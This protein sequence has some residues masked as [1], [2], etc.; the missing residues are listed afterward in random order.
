MW[1]FSQK[2]PFREFILEIEE[3]CARHIRL[4]WSEQ[5][6][7]SN[8]DITVQTAVK[9]RW[10]KLG[11][12]DLYIYWQI[13][14]C[15]SKTILFLQQVVAI[16]KQKVL[17]VIAERKQIVDKKRI[18]SLQKLQETT[19]SILILKI[20]LLKTCF[21]F[22]IIKKKKGFKGGEK[23]THQN[24]CKISPIYKKLYK[25]LLSFFSSRRS[26][27]IQ[28]LHYFNVLASCYL[29]YISCNDEYLV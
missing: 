15:D 2:L 27:I 1:W 17:Y 12:F 25:K 8:F 20:L 28:I 6:R 3:V 19:A 5:I 18:H 11:V 14:S 24:N 16:H 29:L 23:I 22:I 9:M 10:Q 13:N 4:S 21:L 26:S 7:K